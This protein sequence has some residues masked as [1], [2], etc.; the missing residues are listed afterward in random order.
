MSLE[1]LIDEAEILLVSNGNH[2]GKGGVYTDVTTVEISVDGEEVEFTSEMA[3][4]PDASDEN[5]TWTV[6]A[7]FV[8]VELVGQI[9]TGKNEAI[10]RLDEVTVWAAGEKII[11]AG[12]EMAVREFEGTTMNTSNAI[13]LTSISMDELYER[14]MAME[15]TAMA[16][17][18]SITNNY[19]ELAEMLGNL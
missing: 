7:D 3:F 2:S 17:A 15:G 8:K 10:V 5:F 4:E 18:E 12:L 13:D 14:V 6:D 9:T 16:W 11:S 19:P 1:V